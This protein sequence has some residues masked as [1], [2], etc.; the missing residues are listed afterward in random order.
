[1]RHALAFFE[2]IV[3]HKISWGFESE[4]DLRKCQTTLTFGDAGTRVIVETLK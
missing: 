2:S 3:T 1:M 4:S